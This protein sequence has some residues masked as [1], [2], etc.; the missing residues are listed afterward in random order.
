LAAGAL[1]L[2]A[3]ALSGTEW[4]LWPAV[5]AAAVGL[6]TAVGVTPELG[7]QLALFAVLSVASTF[8]SRSLARR[9]R[10]LEVATDVNDPHARLLGRPGEVVA[11][12]LA[13]RGRVLVDGAEW[14]AEL[15]DDGELPAGAGVEVVE[16]LDGARLRVRPL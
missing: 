14:R 13:G 12:F 7:E 3:E 10:A 2:T 9:N 1:M 6:L 15:D 11:P 4:L 8:A 16:R 5:S